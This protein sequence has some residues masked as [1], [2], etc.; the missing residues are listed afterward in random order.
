[1]NKMGARM[2][3]ILD[4]IA[5]ADTKPTKAPRKSNIELCRII[6]M[7]LII[8]HHC[9]VH[10]GA[11]EM[12]FCA[13]KWLAIFLVPGGKLCF[14]CFLAISTWFL[15]DQSFKMERFIK[16]WVQVLFYSIVF[17]ILA[18]AMGTV[19][20]I[21]NWFSILF[22]IAG[23][24]HGFAAAYL[25]F[26]LILPFLA[27]ISESITKKQAAWL[28][29]ILFYIEIITQIIGAV[30]LYTQPLNSELLLFVLFYFISLY[31]KRYPL[32]ILESKCLML[33]IVIFVWLAIFAI[34]SL[35][36]LL[37]QNRWVSLLLSFNVS[38]SSMLFVIGGFAV[39]FFFYGIKMPAIPI[40]N[41]IATATFG[42]LLIHDHNFFRYILWNEIVKA[43]TWYYSKY[44]MLRVL[45]VTILIFSICAAIELIRARIF[46]RYILHSAVL[47]GIS[48]KVNEMLVKGKINADK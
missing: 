8:A 28:V 11:M 5:A 30:S 22:P 48:N 19:F 2:S 40:I 42:V 39:F 29:A 37:P 14:D 38:E 10:G 18:F 7:L 35:T 25:A 17:S 32:K 33:S 1:M 20:S 43:P 34:F 45:L 46:E 13:N 3:E 15:V 16:V 27:K 36:Y 31:L 44:F 24:S 26:Y 23:N 6:C 12:N 41:K 47:S 21:R 4:N 9:V